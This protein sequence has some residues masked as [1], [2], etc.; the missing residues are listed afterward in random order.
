[1]SILQKLRRR[2]PEQGLRH[3]L[4]RPDP[5]HPARAARARDPGRGQRRRRQPARPAAQALVEVAR[6]QGA[7]GSADRHGHRRRHPRP[8]RRADRRRACRWPT[9]TTAG[10]STRSATA[11]SRPTSTSVRFRSPRRLRRGAQIVVTGRTT[12][13]GLVLSPLIAEF[14]W[15]RGPVGPARRRHG[16]RAHRRVRRPVHRRQLLAL[17]GGRGLGPP[18]L[19]GARS[20]RADGTLRRDQARGHRRAGHAWTRSPSSWSTR[21]AIRRATS[22]RTASSTSP[23]SGWSRQAPDRVRVHGVRGGR[24]TD[25]Y[26]VSISYLDGYKATGQLTVSGPDAL[27][28]ARIC[29]DALWGRLRRAGYTFE[30]TLTEFVGVDCL[31]RRRSP[32]ARATSTRS[33]CASAC[34]DA[35]RAKVDRFGKELAPLVTSGPARR[36]RVRRRPAQGDRGARLLAG[37]DP[38]GPGPA[39]GRAWR[40]CG[41]ADPALRHGPRPLGR[42]GRRLQ[43]RRAGLRRPRLRDPARA[44]DPRAGQGATSAGSSAARSSAS[45][46]PTCSALNFLLHD[47]LGGGGSASLKTDAQGKTHAMALLRM[48]VEVPDDYEPPR[49]GRSGALRPAASCRA[50]GVTSMSELPLDPAAERRRRRAHR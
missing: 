7:R 15:R 18:R 31:P 44:A 24:P 5:A 29:A 21:W 46:C 2:D 25:T 35:D 16:R 8:A 37:A 50:D 41:E 42:Q 38:Q 26:K 43:R 22:R 39:R 48:E 17:V 47:S 32:A 11:C 23:R 19:P 13:P 30:E 4:R 45:R 34:K 9:W 6:E 27:A 10:R 33:C 28:K 3:R 20:A 40:R 49:V 14:G 36:D 1:M 12:D